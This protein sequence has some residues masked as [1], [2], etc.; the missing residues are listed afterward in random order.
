MKTYGDMPDSHRELV[1]EL[2]VLEKYFDDHQDTVPPEA[3]AKGFL[4]CAHD[5]YSLHMGEEGQ[6]LLYRAEARC[7]GYFA[8]LLD[9]QASRDPDFN[10][11]VENLKKTSAVKTFVRLG[12]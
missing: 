10:I 12:Y 1:K 11:L 7:P 3:A 2:V 8:N 4:C 6:R 9:D 5:W